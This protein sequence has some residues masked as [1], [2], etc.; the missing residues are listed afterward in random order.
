MAFEIGQRVTS[1][2][3]GAGTVKSDLSRHIDEDDPQHPVTYQRVEF[4]KNGIETAVDVAK[5]YP[6]DELHEIGAAVVEGRVSGT[7]SRRRG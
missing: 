7:N 4:D 6:L 2:F 3:F 1:K 5:L